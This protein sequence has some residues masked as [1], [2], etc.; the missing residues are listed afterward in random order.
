[1]SANSKHSRSGVRQ[2]YNADRMNGA[3]A[4][5]DRKYRAWLKRRGLPEYEC[6][7]FATK[8]RKATNEISDL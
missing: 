3:A 4:E 6:G 8:K 1:M 7:Y 2:K 5:I